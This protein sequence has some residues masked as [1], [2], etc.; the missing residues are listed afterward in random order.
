MTAAHCCGRFETVNSPAVPT[1]DC[2]SA[3]S[4]AR[5]IAIPETGRFGAATMSGCDGIVGGDAAEMARTQVVALLKR[6]VA[7]RQNEFRRAVSRSALDPGVK[8]LLYFVNVRAA[9]HGRGDLTCPT[10]A[11][12]TAPSRTV[13]AAGEVIA[14]DVRRLALSIWRAIRKRHA[15]PDPRRIAPVLDGRIA[16]VSVSTSRHADLWATFRFAGGEAISVPLHVNARR[17]PQAHRDARCQRIEIVPQG[18][19]FAVRL[20]G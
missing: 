4:A 19:S 15:K 6:F 9:W 3:S 1:R 13:P 20:I 10:C 17:A 8:R 7:D 11:S 12:A 2:L 5:T 14:A 18:R 16:A